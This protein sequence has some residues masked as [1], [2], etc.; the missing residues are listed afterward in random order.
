MESRMGGR[1][2][3]IARCCAGVLL[4]LGI[5]SESGA[6]PVACP[7]SAGS[8]LCQLDVGDTTLFVTATSLGG[9]GLTVRLRIGDEYQLFREVF[10]IYSFDDAEF[11]DVALLSA[12]QDVQASTIEVSFREDGAGAVDASVSFQLTAAGGTNEID[13]S[14]SITAGPGLPSGVAASGRLYVL[15]DYDLGDFATDDDSVTATAGGSLITQTDGMITGTQEV[16]GPAP[17]AFEVAFCCDLDPLLLDLFLDLDGTSALSGPDD[18]QFA[19]SWDRA[20]SDSAPFSATVRKTITAP[21][22]SATA[23]Q[24]SALLAVALL[25]RTR[26]SVGR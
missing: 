2:R 9:G 24:V 22:P 21:E 14:L 6:V 11:I 23:L 18:F 13:E 15:T 12:T 19:V 25:L 4:L 17:T 16:I 20:I 5:A 7:E 10:K 3:R 26:R 8:S 1:L